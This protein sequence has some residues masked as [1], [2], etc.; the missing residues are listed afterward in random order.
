M[1]DLTLFVGLDVHEKTISVPMV[2]A[3]TGAEAR[4]YGTIARHHP[5]AVPQQR[6]P[7]QSRRP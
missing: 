1:A 5:G 4:F 2:E 6:H 7:G 3:A